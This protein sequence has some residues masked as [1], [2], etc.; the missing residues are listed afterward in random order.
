V[1]MKPTFGRVSRYG[2]L[3]L[4]PTLDH[5][6]PMTRTVVDN[7]IML[8][9]LSGF[10]DKD[11]Y[12]VHTRAEEFFQGI[13]ETIKGKKI[14]IPSSFYFDIMHPEVQTIFAAAIDKMKILGADIEYVDL[15]GMDDIANALNVIISAEAY[16]SLG[17]KFHEDPC[18]LGEEV[19]GRLELGMQVKASEY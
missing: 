13:E 2:A 12:S 5:L 4:S 11:P 7:A 10:D 9:A 18:R 19:K 17:M 15:P 14:G 3:P 8:N 6:G 16:A 1:G